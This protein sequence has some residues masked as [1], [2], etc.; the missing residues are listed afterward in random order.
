MAPPI[1]VL[2]AV[3]LLTLVGA[4]LLLAVV[5]WA[6]RGIPRLKNALEKE[7]GHFQARVQFVSNVFT[8]LA[9][10]LA[11]SA[12]VVGIQS[13]QETFKQANALQDEA[14]ATTAAQNYIELRA[15]HPK[16][17]PQYIVND[18]GEKVLNEEYGWVALDALATT[19]IIY[20]SMTDED[21]RWIDCG[22]WLTAADIIKDNRGFVTNPAWRTDDWFRPAYYNKGFR[23]FILNPDSPGK[24]EC[25][26][27]V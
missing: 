12:L 26:G 7:N 6:S 13:F 9:G 5:W 1:T 4:S 15:D 27:A 17:M 19:E 24:Q 22:W 3:L 2:L 25:H 18:K 21:G 16:E 14:A 8:I 11:L 23:T 10:I 20:L